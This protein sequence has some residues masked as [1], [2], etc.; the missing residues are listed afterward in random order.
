MVDNLIRL[1]ESTATSFS[2]NGIG[3]LPNASKC[4]VVEERNGSYE[5][6]LEYPVSGKR[7][8]ELE[9]RRIIVAR[10]NPYSSPQPFR[11]Y[12]ISKSMNGLVTVK[13]EHI[14]YD[15]SG[16]PVAPFTAGSVITA[17]DGVRNGCI[18][19]CPFE[20]LTD[21]DDGVSAEKKMIVTK[22]ETMRSLLGGS[23]NSILDIFGG[24]YEFDQYRVILHKKRGTNRGVAIRYGKN[25]T[26][27]KQEENCSNVYTAVYPY[28]L[29]ED[30]E[31]GQSILIEIP[32]KTVAAPGTYNFTRI[33]PLDVSGSWNN[34]YEWEDEYPSEEE[35]REI[36]K[37]YISDNKIGIPKVSLTVSFELLSQ[38]KEYEL[39]SLLEQ[40]HLCDT[41]NVIFPE[42]KVSAVSQCIKTTYNVLTGKYISIELGESR[43]NLASAIASRNEEVS[44]DLTNRPTLSYM[45]QAVEKATLLISG[46]LGG[47]VVIRS[48]TGGN[49]P[50]EILIM[51]TP[52]VS[53]ASKVWRWNKAGL[54]YSENGYDGPYVT[55]ITQDGEIVADFVKTGS[56]TA[57]IIKGGTLTVGGLENTDGAIEVR[58]SRGNLLIKLGVDG[59][60]FYGTGGSTVTKIVNDTLQTTNVTATNLKVAAANIT[61]TLTANQINTTNL[62]VAAA[63]ITGTLTASQINTANL[64]VAAAN[65]TGTLTA[66]QI[67]AA[68]L[69]AE[70]FKYSDSNYECSLSDGFLIYDKSESCET[71]YAIKGVHGSVTLFASGLDF[72]TGTN[73]NGT[74]GSFWYDNMGFHFDRSI[75]IGTASIR[76]GN[77]G[78]AT[79]VDCTSKGMFY[80]GAASNYTDES[81]F[82]ALRG[83]TVRIY[84][85]KSGAVY[86][87]Y[88]GSTAITSDETLKD[89]YEIDPRY[90]E[91]FMNLTPVLY[92][93]KERGHRRHIGYGA[94]AVEKALKKAGLSTEEFAGILIDRDV[95]IGSD[96]MGTDED[97]HFDELYSLRYEEFGPL[98]AHMLK[99]AYQRLEEQQEEIGNLKSKTDGQQKEIGNLKSKVD[100][101]Q[102]RINELSMQIKE[103]LIC[104]KERM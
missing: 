14:S 9:L 54:G 60:A 17:L 33:C 55:A 19:P 89:I 30:S 70:S 12:D 102:Q 73:F 80:Y 6:E 76:A 92:T 84:S 49:H 100:E 2:T 96:E 104:L 20:F 41:V 65:I 27:L 36:A 45:A 35:I 31:T 24:E 64:R 46:G 88:S 91:F 52:D 15:M 93:Y 101:Q 29:F 82:S 48:S 69:V 66:S 99:K 75:D 37:K 50:D 86:L 23:D 58:D 59:I 21:I 63:N 8:S 47:Y 22:P 38:A 71:S 32:E 7:Y 61:G 85:H 78:N 95:T 11:I 44:N 83:K 74:H 10:P 4:E 103:A 26:D 18:T 67:N 57:S 53:T 25:M 16:Y 39:L 13:A 3:N 79:I 40:V 34:T 94:R 56:L 90:E 68:G 81:S 87:G 5:L 62:R 97:V 77:D 51:D 42:L 28:F 43:S 98:Y 1:F 72:Y